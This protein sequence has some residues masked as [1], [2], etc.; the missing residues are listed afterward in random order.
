MELLKWGGFR[1]G[2]E[3]YSTSVFGG[4]VFGDSFWGGGGSIWGW[5]GE[6][7]QNLKGKG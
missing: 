1:V 3:G 4:S 7:K 2:E 5:G 6:M